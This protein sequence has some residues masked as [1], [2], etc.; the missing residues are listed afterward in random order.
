M[1]SKAE[2]NNALNIENGGDMAFGTFVDPDWSDG[3]GDMVRIVTKLFVF[4]EE[5]AIKII[6]DLWLIECYNCRN[7]DNYENPCT[8]CAKDRPVIETLK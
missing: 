7:L 2:F 4:Q 5:G 1:V 6:D 3:D 8:I